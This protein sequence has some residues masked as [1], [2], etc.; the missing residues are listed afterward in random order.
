MAAVRDPMPTQSYRSFQKSAAC[1]MDVTE[2]PIYQDLK[3][4]PPKF[5]ETAKSNM[6]KIPDIWPY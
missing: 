2:D 5:I 1:N 4:R 6:V 3:K